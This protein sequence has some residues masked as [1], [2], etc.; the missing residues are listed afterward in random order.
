M[1]ITDVFCAPVEAKRVDNISI[2]ED[3]VDYAELT[4]GL[5]V[6]KSGNS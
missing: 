1:S 3:I 2:I 5:D 6:M 4:L